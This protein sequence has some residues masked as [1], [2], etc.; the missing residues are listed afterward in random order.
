MKDFLSDIGGS[1]TPS[2][3]E[4]KLLLATPGI[5]DGSYFDRSIIYI[6][7][8]S[9]E[10]AIGLIVNQ[11]MPMVEFDDLHENIGLKKSEIRIRPEILFGGPVDTGRGFVLHS[12]EYSGKH[13]I[14]LSDKL[15]LNASTDILKSIALG[16]GPEKSL[17]VLGYAG[18]GPGQL[19]EEIKNN[20]WLT[21][22]VQEDILFDA[23][24]DNKWECA[25]NS[26]GVSP[27]HLSYT[28]GQA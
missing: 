2:P 5:N 20:Y 7:A 1:G 18:W 17:F 11:P 22:D 8:H 28:T 3:Y 9:E 4:G 19:E 12:T 16:D 6:C 27:Q 25:L 14:N 10:G 24:L 26:L 15:A 23:S 21:S 13:S